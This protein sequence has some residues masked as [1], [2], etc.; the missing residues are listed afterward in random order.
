[1]A[2]SLLALTSEARLKIMSPESLANQFQS[3][4]SCSTAAAAAITAVVAALSES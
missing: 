2:C 4:S 3:K 1:M